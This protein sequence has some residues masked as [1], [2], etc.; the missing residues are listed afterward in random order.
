MSGKTTYS[1]IPPVPQA[2]DVVVFFF[3]NENIYTL[4]NKGVKT[5]TEYIYKFEKDVELQLL[6]LKSAK[7]G[8]L[9]NKI[10]DKQ[11][12]DFISQVVIR[13]Y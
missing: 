4:P 2:P 6:V 9:H 8:Y 1:L 10:I 11:L 13:F 3:H 7:S 12:S 5:I